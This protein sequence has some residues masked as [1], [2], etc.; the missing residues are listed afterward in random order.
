MRVGVKERKEKIK[1][2]LLLIITPLI[3]LALLLAYAEAQKAAKNVKVLNNRLSVDLKDAEFGGVMQEIA[4]MAGFEVRISA[5][6]SNKTLSTSFR[7][8]DLQRGINRL[9]TLISQKNFFIYYGPDNAISRIEVFAPVSRPGRKST[10][11]W[12]P[13]TRPQPE[14]P[15]YP[16]L[17]PPAPMPLPGSPVLPPPAPMPLPGSPV[18]PGEKPAGEEPA[19]E[20]PAGEEP[21]G[22]EPAEEEPKQIKKVPYIQPTQVPVYIP[23]ARETE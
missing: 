16:V 22:E 2:H 15:S 12:K 14:R 8:I 17:P 18:L 23:P 5:A 4:D 19:G 11:T 6:I 20:E 13:D 3:V 10:T 9:L 1:V 7:D 21:A